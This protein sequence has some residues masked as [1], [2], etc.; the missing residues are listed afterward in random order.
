MEH[1]KLTRLRTFNSMF[2][3]RM[4]ESIWK[5][6]EELTHSVLASYEIRKMPSFRN[7]ETLRLQ[8]STQLDRPLH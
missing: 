5:Q 8:S 1:L 6:D 2:Q 7:L 4:V 3:I